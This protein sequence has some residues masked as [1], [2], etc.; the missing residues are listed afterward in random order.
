[1]K[2][3]VSVFFLLLLC[4]TY[5]PAQRA[6]AYFQSQAICEI[7]GPSQLNEIKMLGSKSRFRDFI[8]P[9]EFRG[10]QD[11]QSFLILDEALFSCYTPDVPTPPPN[12][13]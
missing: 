11:T 9:G 13:A 8:N 6:T 7:E 12:K 3:W 4:S 10:I 2:S 5:I 1:M